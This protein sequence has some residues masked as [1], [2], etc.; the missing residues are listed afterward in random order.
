MK[1]DYRLVLVE[2]IHEYEE[3]GWRLV[4]GR[5]HRALGGWPSV[6]MKREG[7]GDGPDGGQGAGQP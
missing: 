3:E 6:Y 2:R 4:S 5:V 7:D 1:T